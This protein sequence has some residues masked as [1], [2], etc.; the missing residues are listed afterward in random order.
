M[1]CSPSR[2]LNSIFSILPRGPGESG[3]VCC[4]LLS[5][6]YVQNELLSL[7]NFWN[8]PLGIVSVSS[9]FLGYLN[10][11]HHLDRPITVLAARAQCGG[12]VQRPRQSC[13]FPPWA[14]SHVVVM[15]E[16][17]FL[18]VFVPGSC[19]FFVCQLKVPSQLETPTVTWSLPSVLRSHGT[20]L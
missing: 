12:T 19:L 11:W 5:T 7:H 6:L 15:S 2:T 10:V 4:S 20:D 17:F 16:V 14:V 8:D 9:S 13:G 1:P 18:P 3:A